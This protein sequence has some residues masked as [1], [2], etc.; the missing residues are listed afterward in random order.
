MKLWLAIVLALL[1]VVVILQNTA[2]VTVNFL[3]WDAS[4]SRVLL[5]LITLLVGFVIGFVVAKLPRRQK[6]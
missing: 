2:V 6:V 1:A 5:L 4:L 3:F